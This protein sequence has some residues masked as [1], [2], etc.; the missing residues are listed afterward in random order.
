MKGSGDQLIPYLVC[1]LDLYNCTSVTNFSCTSPW[2]KINVYTH[3]PVCRLYNSP[4]I[5]FA[6]FLLSLNSYPNWCALLSTRLFWPG[7]PHTHIVWLVSCPD[8]LRDYCLTWYTSTR[9]FSQ[10]MCMAWEQ[11]YTKLTV[12][13]WNVSGCA[14]TYIHIEITK[15]LCKSRLTRKVEKTCTWDEF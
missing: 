2:S 14:A 5:L 15:T 11:G 9:P 12:A 10:T 6:C 1:Q 4:N 8:P 7:T 13:T 3:T